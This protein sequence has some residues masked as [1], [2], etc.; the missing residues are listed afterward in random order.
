MITNIHGTL[1]VSSSYDILNDENNRKKFEKQKTIAADYIRRNPKPN[2]YCITGRDLREEMELTD[3]ELSCL[4]P[5]SDEE[6]A[7]IKELLVQT[8]NEDSDVCKTWHKS[9]RISQ[10]HLKE[11]VKE[12]QALHSHRFHR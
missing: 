4:L 9:H 8:Y 7:R 6:V 2:F 12:E 1:Y 10:E 11:G 3:S 5:F